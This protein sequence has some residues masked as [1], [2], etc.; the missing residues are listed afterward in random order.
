LKRE[1]AGTA[2]LSTRSS[3]T[4]RAIRLL[5]RRRRLPRLAGGF[6]SLARSI[7]LG[8]TDGLIEGGPLSPFRRAIS[9]RCSATTCFSADTSPNNCSTSAF[10]AAAERSSRSAG[11][12]MP[13]QDL[14]SAVRGIG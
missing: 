14:K 7:P 2:V 4:T 1:P 10:S 5:P 11:G 3:T 8:L 12:D 13:L 9:A 6:A